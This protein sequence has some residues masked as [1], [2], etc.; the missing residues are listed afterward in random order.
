MGLPFLFRSRSEE[1]SDVRGTGAPGHS[2]KGSFFHS[3]L[4]ESRSRMKHTA[5]PPHAV[6]SMFRFTH[7][8]MVRI[9]EIE[10][11]LN[12]TMLS[13]RYYINQIFE[14]LEFASPVDIKS[15]LY[16]RLFV[17]N[18]HPESHRIERIFLENSDLR[19]MA[20][21]IMA[22]AGLVESTREAAGFQ[23]AYRANPQQAMS[24]YHFLFNEKTNLN[25]FYIILQS[26]EGLWSVCAQPERFYKFR[27][28]PHSS[29]DL[30]QP[31]FSDF[32]VKW[33]LGK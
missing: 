30:M 29:G 4:A 12:E 10:Q 33:N 27:F 7:G 20:V 19:N 3:T 15:D 6:R 2:P 23:D 28:N 1:G 16:G 17:G 18:S 5:L 21:Q 14:A 24:R 25:R 9:E 31:S 8:T 11:E 22:L 32:W 26:R 13:F